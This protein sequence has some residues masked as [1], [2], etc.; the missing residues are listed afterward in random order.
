MKTYILHTLLLSAAISLPVVSL[1]DEMKASANDLQIQVVGESTPD[2][3]SAYEGMVEAVAYVDMAAQVS[4]AITEK[5]V[6]EGDHVSAGQV[7]L[8]IDA[9]AANQEVLA[10]DAQVAAYQAQLKLS[11]KTF[12]RSSALFKQGHITTEQLEQAEAARDADAA[13]LKA[14]QAQL[15]S[16]RTQAGFFEITA[17]IA[18]IISEISVETG[19]MALP[20]SHLLS[21]YDPSLLRVT[22]ALPSQVTDH[23]RI[24]MDSLIE[25]PSLGVQGTD[26]HPVSVQVLP[27]VDAS[28]MTQNVRFNL[29]QG[30]ISV[31]GQFA[32][33]LLPDASASNS[34]THLFVPRSAIVRRGE[35]TGVYV[36]SGDETPLLRQVRTGLLNAGQIEVLSGLDA[37]DRLI[38]NPALV[39]RIKRAE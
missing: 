8:R 4:G 3:Y 6:T 19:D 12:E 27:K 2:M 34:Q 39:N 33:V 25:I 7:L 22:A 16:A 37:G 1:A 21:L 18:G 28:S 36:L 24:T 17:P 9:R 10:V 35:M 30:T 15:K 13:Q 14:L 11:Q 32:R 5:L 31:P 23:S 38:L 26:L 20:G 29:P